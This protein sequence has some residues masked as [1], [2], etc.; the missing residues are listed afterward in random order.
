MLEN[1]EKNFGKKPKSEKL[2]LICLVF[3]VLFFVSGV[4][5]LTNYL[6]IVRNNLQPLRWSLNINSVTLCLMLIFICLVVYFKI[7]SDKQLKKE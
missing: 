5:C 1:I 7:R 2:L 3:V 6:L 4:I